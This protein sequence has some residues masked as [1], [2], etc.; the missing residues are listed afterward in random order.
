MQ[1]KEFS[2]DDVLKKRIHVNKWLNNYTNA[3]SDKLK[4]CAGSNGSAPDLE[5]IIYSAVEDGFVAFE[6]VREYFGRVLPGQR[7]QCYNM[8]QVYAAY[9]CA[10][11]SLLRL[12]QSSP[13]KEG[14]VDVAAY[15]MFDDLELK[16]DQTYPEQINFMISKYARAL[17]SVCQHKDKG[18]RASALI[19]ATENFFS[20]IKEASLKHL[21]NEVYFKLA[22][23]LQKYSVVVFKTKFAGF[24]DTVNDTD[25][26]KKLTWDDIGGYDDLK[27]EFQDIGRRLQN[28]EEYTQFAN[29]EDLIPKAILLY[30]P[31]GTGKTLIAKTFCENLG[32]EYKILTG[33]DVRSSFVNASA[34]ALQKE[35]NL[36]KN[37]IRSNGNKAYI[38]LIDEVDEISSARN[39]GN[40]REDDKLV[41]VL[42]N[43]LDGVKKVEGVI[44]IGM[45]N[46]YQVMDPSILRRFDMKKEIPL[47]EY[48]L[49]KKVFEVVLNR[50]TR[51][52][53]IS[54]S[55]EIDY[56]QLA[57]L[58]DGYNCG[59]ISDSVIKPIMMQK[60]ER[61]VY[62]KKN[63][64]IT[65]Q[66][67][68]ASIK[69]Y[70]K[71]RIVV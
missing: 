5:N 40:N 70:E 30:G 43:N 44:V 49:R 41:N 6:L 66:D 1:V 8:S 37:R 42:N 53:R 7:E 10:E 15:S 67:V 29:L 16:L 47:P 57:E 38:I 34:N 46:S 71:S 26:E 36:A 19:S 21:D 35:F 12:V 25:G 68:V 58:T 27:K 22:K 56:A 9:V 4:K 11:V 32:V 69:E 50:K 18:A 28:L 45:T 63:Q 51:T 64:I 54:V 61:G 55:A 59:E 13:E 65:T 31:P 3:V 52:K 17:D 2:N 39:T 62:E 20:W 23:E 14:S 60:A 33:T 48:E 24:E